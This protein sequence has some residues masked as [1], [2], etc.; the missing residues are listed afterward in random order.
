MGESHQIRGS[1]LGLKTILARPGTTTL[2]QE[3]R[4]RL[5]ADRSVYPHC[6]HS[7]A[8][9]RAAT[10]FALEIS[11]YSPRRVTASVRSTRVRAAALVPTEGCVPN[12]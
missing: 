4:F 11:H 8:V 12:G 6:R 7:A 2:G 3:R 10:S 9:Q 1:T 5:S